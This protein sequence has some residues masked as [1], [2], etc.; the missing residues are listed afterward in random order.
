M[1]DHSVT[2]DHSKT[3]STIDFAPVFNIAVPMIDRHLA[4][5]RGGYPVIINAD[6]DPGSP[7]DDA[8]EKQITYQQLAVRANQCGNMLKNLVL[9][10]GGRVLMVVKDCPEFFYIFWGAIKAGFVP[11]PLDTLLK[12]DDY[13]YMIE[14]ST[15]A[16]L[17]YSP[18]FLSEITPALAASGHKPGFILAT[19]GPGG[20][21]TQGS[22][23]L[24]FPG[25]MDGYSPVLEPAPATAD[26]ECLWLY[27]SGTTGRPKAAVHRH[28]DIAATCVH[29]AV[30][31]LQMTPDDVCFSA[32]KLFSAYG[33]GNA[34]TFPLW[35]GGVT[36]LSSQRPSPDIIFQ[37]IEEHRP[38]IYF[39]VPSLYAAQLRALDDNAQTGMAADLSS[40]RC[41]VSS[42]E[43]LPADIFRRWQEQ[44]GTLILDGISS[45]EA[46]HVFIS[47]TMDNYRPG[48]SGKPVPGYQVKIMGGQ[49]NPM[50][51][52]DPGML[53]VRG[54]SIA[55]HYWNNP[56]RTAETMV[57]GWLNTGDTYY[58]D[59]DGY[60]VHC[61]RSDDTLKAG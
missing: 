25:L 17:V 2:V 12:A 23:G 58:E 19:D 48:S 43:A 38:S 28:R 54:D 57:D 9:E 60:F 13:R 26:S 8:L 7:A 40:L 61:G 29:Y 18:E 44:T 15:C 16:G 39:A 51:K 3:P 41:C 27:S 53:L 24:Q 52:G 11:V 49:G 59:P 1:P 6:F 46:L 21:S 34:M 47:N 32:A 37:I 14:D 33:M 30:D 36:V 50:T 5:G 4:E 45:T 42:G 35:V 31:T 10:P 22:F 56:Q 20:M 55:S